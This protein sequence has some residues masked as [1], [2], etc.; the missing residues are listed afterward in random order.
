MKLY[1]IFTLAFFSTLFCAAQN[2]FAGDWEGKIG[3]IRLILHVAENDGKLSA[4]LD[5]PDQGA[6]GI[7]CDEITTIGDS[8][9]VKLTIGN[10]A[11]SGLLNTDKNSI[12]GTWKQGGQDV[13]L[14]FKRGTSVSEEIKP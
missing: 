5:S 3:A 9:L 2:P 4:T 13:P 1:L 6:K 7:R 12:T 8:I 14:N 11:Y 10:A